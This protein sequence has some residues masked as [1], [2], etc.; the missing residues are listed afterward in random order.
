MEEGEGERDVSWLVV[1]LCVEEIC[2]VA[3]KDVEPVCMEG[4]EEEA[5]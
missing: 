2:V 4:K 3:G 5:I 1:E